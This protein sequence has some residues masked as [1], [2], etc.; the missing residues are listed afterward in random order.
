ME[1]KQHLNDSVNK[2]AKIV[3]FDDTNITFWGV[4]VTQNI[5]CSQ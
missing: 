3:Y 5:Q 1:A 4:T 2:R